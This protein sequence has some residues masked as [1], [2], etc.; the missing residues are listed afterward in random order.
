MF[1][2]GE[3]KY[4]KKYLYMGAG[5]IVGGAI[6]L[7]MYNTKP[8]KQYIKKCKNSL[9][10]SLDDAMDELMDLVDSISEEK[11]KQKLKN[12]YNYYKRKIEKI[13]FENLEESMKE[14]VSALISE[15]RDLIVSTENM[16]GNI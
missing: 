7:V 6:S 12:K 16:E 1:Y 10:V 2:Y 8:I 9:M 15:I 3:V 5:I 4:M 11:V 13:D 14:K